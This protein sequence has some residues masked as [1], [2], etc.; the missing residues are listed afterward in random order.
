[1][2]T[3]KKVWVKAYEKCMSCEGTGV[4]Q[5]YYVYDD[6]YMEKTCNDCGGEGSWESDKGFVEI[7]IE[8]DE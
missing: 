1:M 7:E 4:Y 6:S 5:K 8:V 2:V 3:K